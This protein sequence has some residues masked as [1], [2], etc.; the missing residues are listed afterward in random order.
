MDN[1]EGK[2]IYKTSSRSLRSDDIMGHRA[3]PSNVLHPPSSDI[4]PHGSTLALQLAGDTASEQH[5]VPEQ[6]AGHLIPPGT[7]LTRSDTIH[8]L[9]PAPV[10]RLGF[11]PAHSIPA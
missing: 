11:R 8:G 3:N 1:I 10:L 4:T 9:V 7:Y 5:A 6:C 2:V